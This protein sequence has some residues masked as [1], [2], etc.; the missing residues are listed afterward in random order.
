MRSPPGCLARLVGFRYSSE[1]LG[2]SRLTTDASRK[3][4]ARICSAEASSGGNS[5]R[6]PDATPL[7]L[8]HMW[9]WASRNAGYSLSVKKPSSTDAA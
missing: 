7:S 8:W 9:H 4:K 2:S 5:K 6:V 3:P 1:A